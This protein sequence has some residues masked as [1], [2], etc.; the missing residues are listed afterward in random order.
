MIQRASDRT[1]IILQGN[2]RNPFTLYAVDPTGADAYYLGYT[3]VKITITEVNGIT[4]AGTV[5]AMLKWRA[6][7]APFS[8][9][10]NVLSANIVFDTNEQATTTFADATIPADSVLW[11]TTSAVASTP[12]KLVANVECTIDA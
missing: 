1:G 3:D 5:T 8:S 6:R 9:G 2:R 10:T 7:T 12:T 11:L 4:D